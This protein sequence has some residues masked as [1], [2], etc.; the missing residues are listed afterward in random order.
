MLFRSLEFEL[1][2]FVGTLSDRN[3]VQSELHKEIARLVA[4]NGVE[5]NFPL[6]IELLEREP[7]N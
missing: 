4:V 5:I 1:R 2:V 7:A 3:P 6:T